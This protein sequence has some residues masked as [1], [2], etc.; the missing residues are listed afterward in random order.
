ML[1]KL[2]FSLYSNANGEI[3]VQALPKTRSL[4]SAQ[5]AK[6]KILGTRQGILCRVPLSVN[7]N[8]RQTKRLDK[9]GFSERRSLDTTWHS[10]K[11]RQ[12]PST[13]EIMQ[14]LRWPHMKS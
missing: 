13:M 7:N 1:I 4:Q 9:G 8:T 10:T 2:I 11:D 5:S 6:C 3:L 12:Q 14:F